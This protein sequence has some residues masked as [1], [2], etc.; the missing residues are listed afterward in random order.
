MVAVN[1]MF[2]LH[3]K[4]RSWAYILPRSINK[5]FVCY[6]HL[7]N[8]VHVKNFYQVHASMPINV[9]SRG[10]KCRKDE[11]FSSFAFEDQK[12]RRET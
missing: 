2:G 9:C 6:L 11:N 12:C 5:I 7:I 1:I 3:G 4:Y 8:F 10:W